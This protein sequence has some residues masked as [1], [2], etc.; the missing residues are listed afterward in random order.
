M[1]H[2]A[3]LWAYC[4]LVGSALRLQR[5]R[6]K[7]LLAGLRQELEE[8]FRGM[9]ALSL[10]QISAGV[11]P[12]DKVADELMEGVPE[13]ERQQYMT[14]QRW[15]SW[16]LIALLLIILAVVVAYI[17]FPP[18]SQMLYWRQ[19]AAYVSDEIAGQQEP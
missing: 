10:K 9:G 14:H 12:Y 5:R 6:K 18:R 15:L 8:R 1:T 4:R 13:G 19:D 16:Y 7:E 2:D 11:G 3:A 17:V